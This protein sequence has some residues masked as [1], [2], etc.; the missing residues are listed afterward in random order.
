MAASG[1]LRMFCGLGWPWHLHRIEQRVWHQTGRSAEKTRGHAHRAHE[2][3]WLLR[4]RVD[5]A[6]GC[7][8]YRRA[9]TEKG[10]T[11]RPAWMSRNVYCIR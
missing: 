4:N 9:H 1:G 2:V 3:G 7:A 8:E 10:F 11:Y 6:A 5:G